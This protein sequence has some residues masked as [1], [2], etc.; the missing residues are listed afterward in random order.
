MQQM[1]R[2]AFIAWIYLDQA[3]KKKKKK[4]KLFRSLHLTNPSHYSARPDALQV[5]ILPLVVHKYY[6]ESVTLI[7]D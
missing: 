6:L 4:K 5:L 7:A 1:A 3:K 2:N